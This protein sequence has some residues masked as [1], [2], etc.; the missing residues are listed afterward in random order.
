V[1]LRP[2]ELYGLHGHRVGWLRGQL[3]V[4]DVMTR[5]GLRQWP[6]SKRS[7]RVVPVPPRTLEGMSVLMAG[8][9]RDAL[10]FAAP[11]GGPVTDGHFRN[12]VWYPAVAAA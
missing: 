5:Q 4:V 3:A 12:R 8:L 11:E 7:H 2:G 1:G 10:V 9:P 6:K